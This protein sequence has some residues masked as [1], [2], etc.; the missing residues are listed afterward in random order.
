MS[1]KFMQQLASSGLATVSLL[2]ALTLLASCTSMPKFVGQKGLKENPYVLKINFNATNNCK[3]DSVKE[4]MTICN[5]RAGEFCVKR[6]QWII[7]VS[8]P[9]DIQYRIF[10]D[11]ML[12]RPLRSNRKGFIVKPI[13]E[14]AP[15]AE[16]KYSIVR[17]GCKP[18]DVN[19]F[20]PH[21]RVNK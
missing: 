3:I 12:D 16:Y 4:D 8:N 14:N 19:T 7:W 20:D 5:S 13:N 6:K 1:K 2:A 10:F 11:P 9:A 15:I 21:I 18:D 17:K